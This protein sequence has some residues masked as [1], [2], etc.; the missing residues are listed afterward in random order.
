PGVRVPPVKELHFFDVPPRREK[1][2]AWYRA[3]FP[4]RVSLGGR[5][6][7]GE[8]SPYYMYRPGAIEAI[9]RVLGRVRVIALLRE[10]VSRAFSHYQHAVRK[11]WET[12]GV[13]EAFEDELGRL[14]ELG[15]QV[16]RDPT[17][18]L[19]IHQQR[20]YI[21]RGQYAEQIERLWRHIPRERTLII[22][23]EALFRDC[24]AVAPR[25]QAFL[26]LALRDLM[27]ERVPNRGRYGEELSYALSRRL[28]RHFAP[29]NQRLF[30]M[31]GERFDWPV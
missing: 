2:L 3:C 16:E 4:L 29:H 28:A 7:T 25:V 1:G 6:I 10:P 15:A 5:W 24:A 26:G 8:A 13:E 27:L 12:R 20:S 31:L 18:D 17:R 30:E 22:Q 21:H 23:S 11:G 9:A 19:P 14:G